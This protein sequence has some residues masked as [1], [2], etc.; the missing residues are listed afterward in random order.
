MIDASRTNADTTDTTD[1]ELGVSLADPAVAH[2]FEDHLTDL[3]KDASGRIVYRILAVVIVVGL[4]AHVAGYLLR[5]TATSEPLG[6]LADLL[7]TLGWGLWTGAVIVVVVQIIPEVKR[8]QIKRA[9][10]AYE[11]TRR[12]KSRAG[13]GGDGK[14]R[15]ERRVWRRR[16]DSN[17]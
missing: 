5:T 14:G 17:R 3:R 11:A 10:D 4:V 2:W 8:Q 16:P 7:Y 12:T 6:L 1:D 13:Q 15:F 9:V